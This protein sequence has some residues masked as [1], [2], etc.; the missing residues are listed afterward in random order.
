MKRGRQDG[1]WILPL[2]EQWGG[3]L[4]VVVR[5]L[6]TALTPAFLLAAVASLLNVLTTRLARAV[7]RSRE[8]QRSLGESAGKERQAI[9]DELAIIGKR[10]RLSR[11][12]IL[13]S[14]T[15]AVVIC[16][17]V[18]LLFLMGIS[19]FSMAE[20]IVSMFTLAMG[21]IA[22]ALIALLWETTLAAHEVDI[23]DLA[24]DDDGGDTAATK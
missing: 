22:F 18:A 17:M 4:E 8:L 11:I 9:R 14:V 20:L 24:A 13:F 23:P 1:N 6:Q 16:I 5:V 15:G 21:L 2:Q 10:K 7:D 12:S 19:A 3:D